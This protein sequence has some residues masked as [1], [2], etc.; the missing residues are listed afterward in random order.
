MCV[1]YAFPHRFPSMLPYCANTHVRDAMH[2]SS[3]RITAAKQAFRRVGR[4]SGFT[5]RTSDVRAPRCRFDDQ[6]HEPSAQVT[7][8]LRPCRAR[9]ASRPSGLYR[10]G[11]RA[12][13]LR[14]SVRSSLAH[15]RARSTRQVRL[16]SLASDAQDACARNRCCTHFS[17]SAVLSA[18]RAGDAHSP[19]HCLLLLAR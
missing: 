12:A 5:R 15:P 8:L 1:P 11:R 9:L 4:S 3:E 10:S 18:S 16:A 7:L 13:N 2:A 17:S 6:A 14:W 19:L